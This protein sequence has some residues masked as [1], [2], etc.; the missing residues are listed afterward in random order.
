MRMESCIKC[1]GARFYGAGSVGWGGQICNCHEPVFQNPP[2]QMQQN[3]PSP[4][5]QT[6]IDA[7]EARIMAVLK[8]IEEK[9]DSKQE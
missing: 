8:R 1:G 2:M 6:A 5:P 7:S 9:L 3:F 4:W